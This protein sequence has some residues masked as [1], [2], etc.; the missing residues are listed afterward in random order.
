M[1]K[2]GLTT[3]LLMFGV[4]V[5]AQPIP[6]PPQPILSKG[7]SIKLE[8]TDANG[9][10]TKSTTGLCT[11]DGGCTE[12]DVIAALNAFCSNSNWG[13][14]LFLG[15]GGFSEYEGDMRYADAAGA[16]TIV[17]NSQFNYSV[18]WQ[19]LYENQVA[20]FD[21]Q[22]SYNN[23]T[24]SSIASANALGYS[25]QTRTYNSNFVLQVPVNV[26]V[27]YF[28]IRSLTGESVELHKIT[29]TYA[30]STPADRFASPVNSGIQNAV[31]TEISLFPNPA[32]DQCLISFG[33]IREQS[34]QQVDLY[35]LA[36][37]LIASQKYSGQQVISMDL[38]NFET[39]VYF[40]NI[41][42]GQLVERKKLVK[43]A[44]N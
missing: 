30:E 13:K 35:D 28:R 2:I 43:I 31:G 36:G 14:S 26:S 38:K 37:K 1:K 23:S 20:T 40:V 34:L 10:V 7:Q 29:N 3:V 27:I 21:I 8:C 4:M 41:T 6:P 11:A 33:D 18:V 19:T 44:G 22:Y 5:F 12:A 15:N 9:R 25:Q 32:T 42:N 24:W 39:G 17:K 16:L